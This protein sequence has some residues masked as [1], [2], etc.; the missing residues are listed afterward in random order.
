M[1]L[2]MSSTSDTMFWLGWLPYISLPLLP[3]TIAF[4]L[5][6]MTDVVIL[7]AIA[8]LRNWKSALRILQSYDLRPLF[9]IITGVAWAF[10]FA[11]IVKLWRNSPAKKKDF[12]DKGP[13]P[14]FFPARTTHTRI[15]P[16][17][18]SFSYS[19]LLVGIPV[20]WQGSVG[21]ML[22]ADQ[23]S[24]AVK[25]CTQDGSPGSGWYTVDAAD[26]LERGNGHLGLHGKLGKFLESQVCA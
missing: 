2:K 13:R 6:D 4:G 3:L 11:Q 9:G 26:Y 21:G 24:R 15:F 5:A 16:K 1:M 23:G 22:A 19:Y 18:H 25:D 12:S 20:G 7:F 8:I 10:V 17:V 14:L